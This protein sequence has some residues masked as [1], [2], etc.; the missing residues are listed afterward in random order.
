MANF[1]KNCGNKLTA[2]AKFCRKCGARIEYTAPAQN[3][4]PETAA[5]IT[6]PAGNT[7]AKEPHGSR[8]NKKAAGRSGLSIFLAA[9]IVVEFLVAGLKIGRAHV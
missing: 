3:S 6:R 4:M 7:A 8:T 5:G 1:C 9:A 2:G